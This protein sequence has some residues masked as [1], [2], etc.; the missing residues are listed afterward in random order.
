MLKHIQNL[1]TVLLNLE[2]VSIIILEAE[3]QF[4]YI[5]IKIMGYIC[6]SKK[7]HPDI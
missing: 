2:K 6:N 1:D 4:F 7:R 3:S 5:S